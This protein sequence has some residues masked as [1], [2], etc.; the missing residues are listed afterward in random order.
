[1]QGRGLL[2]GEHRPLTAGDDDRVIV[3]QSDAGHRFGRV[4]RL[5]ERWRRNESHCNEVARGVA[6]WISRITEGVR[7]TRAAIRAEEVYA[8]PAFGEGEVRV[9]QFAPPE[10]DGPPGCG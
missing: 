10:S 1:M 8:I 3:R 5:R 9:R 7:F 6:A 4:D 2:E